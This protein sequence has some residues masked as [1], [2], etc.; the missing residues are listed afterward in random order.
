MLIFIDVYSQSLYAKMH[1]FPEEKGIQ[2]KNLPWEGY[3]YFLE[4]NIAKKGG[5]TDSL[6]TRKLW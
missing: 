2:M 3:G 1:L 5:D 6:D 4:Q